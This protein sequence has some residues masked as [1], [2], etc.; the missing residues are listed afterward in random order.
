MRNIEESSCLVDR[1]V[2]RI[3][4]LPLD[5]GGGS[6]QS[7]S[8]LMSPQETE[9]TV[10]LPPPLGSSSCSCS[11]PSV[12]VRVLPSLR[13]EVGVNCVCSATSPPYSFFFIFRSSGPALRDQR[14]EAE[15]RPKSCH[16]APHLGTQLLT[17][18]LS[19]LTVLRPRGDSVPCLSELW[20][21]QVTLGT[22]HLGAAVF[23]FLISLLC[24]CV[25]LH[26]CLAG[27]WS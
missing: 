8:F 7:L 13:E 20:E 12:P 2:S 15:Q 3:M 1:T 11:C 16:K 27:P 6:P 10:L 25:Q 9:T 17:A 4:E 5:G 22:S 19:S 18:Q 23:R 26:P 14:W 24:V 21:L